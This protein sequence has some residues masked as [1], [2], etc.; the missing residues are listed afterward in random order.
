[1]A[2]FA[3]AN[4]RVFGSVKPVTINV[5]VLGAPIEANRG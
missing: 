2:R 5:F 1:M 4:T 3:S